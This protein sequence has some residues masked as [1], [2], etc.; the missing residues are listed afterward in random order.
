MPLSVYGEYG[1]PQ[2]SG[3]RRQKYL[4][5]FPVYL[6]YFY[7]S[8]QNWYGCHRNAVLDRWTCRALETTSTTRGLTSTQI[9]LVLYA[10][11]EI[12]CDSVGIHSADEFGDC[13]WSTEPNHTNS[14]WI[15]KI[16]DEASIKMKR[17]TGMFTWFRLRNADDAKD[18]RAGYA[19]TRLPRV[20]GV[21][22]DTTDEACPRKSRKRCITIEKLVDPEIKPD[23]Q[24]RLLERP[25][26]CPKSDINGCW[27]KT[28]RELPRTGRFFQLSFLALLLSGV[29]VGDKTPSQHLR[30]MMHLQGKHPVNDAVLKELWQ[31]SLSTEVRKVLSVI[32][33]DSSL[34][35]LAEAASCYRWYDIRDIEENTHKDADTLV[36]HEYGYGV[37]ASRFMAIYQSDTMKDFYIG[38]AM[39]RST[40]V[41]TEQK[42]DKFDC[43]AKQ[44]RISDA[45]TE[46]ILLPIAFQL[47]GC[48]VCLQ[49][50]SP[51]NSLS[52]VQQME[53]VPSSSTEPNKRLIY[54]DV[55]STPYVIHERI[56]FGS[57]RVEAPERPIP[58][59]VTVNEVARHI[60]AQ[61]NQCLAQLYISLTSVVCSDFIAIENYGISN[62]MEV[63]FTEGAEYQLTVDMLISNVRRLPSMELQSD[64]LCDPS[65]HVFSTLMVDHLAEKRVHA[66]KVCDSSF[67]STYRRWHDRSCATETEQLMIWNAQC[68]T[69]PAKLPALAH[70]SIEFLVAQPNVNF[71]LSRFE[72]ICTDQ[73]GIWIRDDRGKRTVNVSVRLLAEATSHSRT[74]ERSAP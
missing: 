62:R 29:D 18:A 69:K 19:G 9:S 74:T 72:F 37:N 61:V 41:P 46:R 15:R 21:T 39:P 16:S 50:S 6:S 26:D 28:P 4:S 70:S 63:A 49:R 42:T 20:T 12:I 55:S 10:T 14:M 11:G 30:H 56:Q 66:D 24:N 48:D 2:P 7:T 65:D 38:L 23:H 40:C 52:C 33:Q 57:D 68:T 53:V 32:E 34:A 35:K 5:D 17:S 27:E 22:V 13:C 8:S 47:N 71:Q 73:H 51:R 44:F 36:S 45:A 64:G 43:A 54:V 60:F 67:D 31:Q 3:N 59:T 58:N 1:G 25:P